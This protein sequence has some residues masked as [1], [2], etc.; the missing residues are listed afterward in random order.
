MVCVVC[1]SGS[2]CLHLF[3]LVCCTFL[4]RVSGT[5]HRVSVAR[6]WCV[7]AS[8]RRTCMAGCLRVTEMYLLT[9]LALVFTCVYVRMPAVDCVT[10]VY[11][12]APTDFDDLV[13]AGMPTASNVIILPM[14]ANKADITVDAKPI[15]VFRHC[16]R[17]VARPMV[18][19]G[20]CQQ[21]AMSV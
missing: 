5:C 7:S 16:K 4:V 3:I 15:M 21:W 9:C 1:V 18:D 13:R 19:I 6:F 11:Q 10:G 14:G 2:V 12:G 20:K 8:L 17:G